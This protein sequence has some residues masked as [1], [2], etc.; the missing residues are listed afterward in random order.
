MWLVIGCVK[1]LRR[2]IAGHDR[3]SDEEA[4][5]RCAAGAA[6]SSRQARR[7]ARGTE[8]LQPRVARAVRQEPSQVPAES[9]G[10]IPT[11]RRTTDEDQDPAE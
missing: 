3:G 6:T 10:D 11:G 2:Q 9:S 5:H 4:E 8:E 7:V 1:D